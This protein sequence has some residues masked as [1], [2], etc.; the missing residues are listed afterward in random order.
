MNNYIYHLLSKPLKVETL[1]PDHFPFVQLSK[2]LLRL[3]KARTAHIN[4][5]YSLSSTPKG[6]CFQGSYDMM[7]QRMQHNSSFSRCASWR[8]PQNDNGINLK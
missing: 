2:I 3:E 5:D 8:D 4:Q 7:C 1:E 6:K